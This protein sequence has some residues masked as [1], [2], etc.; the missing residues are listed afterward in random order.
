MLLNN[1]DFT[2]VTG[3]SH[4]IVFKGYKSYFVLAQPSKVNKLLNSDLFYYNKSYNMYYNE[5]CK[6][7]V[8]DGNL[9]YLL[10]TLPYPFKGV[11]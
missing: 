1:F 5:K 7:F 10:D 6:I 2:D 11:Y 9:Q 3:Y 8:F 4:Y